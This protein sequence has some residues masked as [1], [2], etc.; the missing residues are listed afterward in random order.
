MET[1]AQVV[2]TALAATTGENEGT[3]VLS[4]G[5]G[6][7]QWLGAHDGVRVEVGHPALTRPRSSWWKRRAAPAED[8][9]RAGLVTAL[10]DLGFTAGDPNYV[11]EISATEVGW[12][13]VT[14]V[15][16]AAFRDVL[17]ITDG[18]AIT[19]ETF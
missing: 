2:K 17:G 9:R 1:V 10:T 13:Q 14:S 5:E 6:V 15:I 12:E 8:P 16:V 18:D 11:R 4:A 7:V 3:A 19:S